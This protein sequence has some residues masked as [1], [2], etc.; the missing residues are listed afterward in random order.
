MSVS[1]RIEGDTQL[2]GLA[3]LQRRMDAAR[4]KVVKVGVPSGPV[5]ADGT[6]M[7]LVASAVE[8]GR[9]SINQPERPFL[10]GGVNDSLPAVRQVA[11]HGLR[12]VVEGTRST[13]A[14]LETMGAVAAGSV[15]QYMAG[16]HFAPNA[17]ATIA[18]KKSSQPTIDT[19]SLRQ[20]VTHVVEAT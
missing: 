19:A 20:S 5:E 3:E 13:E 17:P 4:N 8:F 1:V 15:K 7:A 9:P 2:R 6:S 14:V 10:R 16:D 11:E 12:A 18:K